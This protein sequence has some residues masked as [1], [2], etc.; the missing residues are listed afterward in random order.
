MSVIFCTLFVNETSG[1]LPSKPR[2]LEIIYRPGV[3]LSAHTSV[4]IIENHNG[5][6]YSELLKM[7]HAFNSNVCN[8]DFCPLALIYNCFDLEVFKTRISL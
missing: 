5:E 8:W 4:F 1:G 2:V 7:C 3:F 6:T